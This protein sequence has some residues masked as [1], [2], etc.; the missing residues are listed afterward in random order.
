MIVVLGDLENCAEIGIAVAA[1][2]RGYRPGLIPVL[3]VGDMHW[4]PDRRL[5]VPPWPIY[6]IDGNHDHLPSL[7]RLHE[8]TEVAPNWIYCPRGSVLTFGKTRVGFLGGA[9]SIDRDQRIEGET[10]WRHEELT[11]EEGKRLKGRA[12]DILVTHSPPRFVVQ[13]MGYEETDYSSYVV[14]EVWRDLGRPR[15]VCGHMHRRF[16]SGDITVLGD[17]DAEAIE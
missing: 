6:F 8:P 9:R 15:L 2:A 13:E 3:Q 4:H 11:L 17:L 1:K 10:W 7:L 12:V 16:R 5:P 14:E